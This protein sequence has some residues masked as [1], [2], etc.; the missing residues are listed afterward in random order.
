MS[1]P[2][3]ISF[4]FFVAMAAHTNVNADPWYWPSNT[5]VVSQNPSSSDV[6]TITLSGEW[7]DGCIPNDS[8]VSV[9]ANQIYFD[10]ILDYPPDTV[11]T[12]SIEP[13][14]RTESV[15]PLSPGKYS[16]YTRLI[17]DPAVPE[18][19]ALIT[20]FVIA[21]EQFQDWGSLINGV[22]CVLFQADSGGIYVLDNYGGFNVGDRVRV[23]GTLEPSCTTI[24]MQGDGCI[25]NNTISGRS[26]D[27]GGGSGGGCFISVVTDVSY[28]G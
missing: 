12:L 5:E 9:T 26:D 13:W 14:T 15:G 4:L 10:V 20:E 23:I 27:D 25:L 2:I 1:K 16:V 8:A 19:Y 24:C 22:E 28:K 6:V 3:L 11:C 21:D 17:G 7:P 18:T